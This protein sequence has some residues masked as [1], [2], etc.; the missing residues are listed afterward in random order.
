[1][2]LFEG[3]GGCGGV[4]NGNRRKH[5]SFF[6]HPAFILLSALT[7]SHPLT[8]IGE[9]FAVTGLVVQELGAGGQEQVEATG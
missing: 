9:P 8:F 7:F 4:V 5:K 6:C 2:F 3:L 1:M